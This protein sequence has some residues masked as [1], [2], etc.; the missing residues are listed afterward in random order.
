MAINEECINQEK[1]FLCL[2][3]DLEMYGFT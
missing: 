3:F 2:E 1:V